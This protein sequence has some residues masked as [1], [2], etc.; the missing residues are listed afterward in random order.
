M[1]S[2][3]SVIIATYKRPKHL[4]RAIN[5]VLTQTYKN[6][7][8]IVVDDNNENDEFRKLTEKVLKKLIDENKIIYIQHQHNKGTA[9]ARNT[10]IK[11]ANGEFICFLDDDD[12]YFPLKTESQIKVFQNSEDK[13][14]LVYGSY[15]RKDLRLNKESIIKPKIKGDVSHIIGLN[16]IGPPSIVMCKTSVINIIGGFDKSLPY[17]EDIDFYLR[18]SP[19]CDISYTNEIV[20]KYYTEHKS[21]MSTNHKK[22]LPDTIK[23]IKKHYQ[24]IKKPRLRW[25][26]IQ[27]N[28]GILHVLNDNK[29]LALIAYIKAFLCRPFRISIIIRICLLF[30]GK[31]I[32]TMKKNF[33]YKE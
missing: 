5:S 13:I 21:S 12:E 22:K 3:V 19:Y 30:L 11:E 26:E 1:T 31:K 6:I 17:K 16:K 24:R 33:Y 14:G 10:G 20:T 23:F 25:S 27:E 32:F 4:I 15:L 28:L 7:E 9:D 18:L 29:K 2:L 8:I